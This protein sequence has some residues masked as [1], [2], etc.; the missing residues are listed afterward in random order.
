LRDQR[1]GTVIRL[2]DA[3]QAAIADALRP[4]EF[5]KAAT[6]AKVQAAAE[7]DLRRSIDQGQN[8]VPVMD[9]EGNVSLGFADKEL[10]DIDA[11]L[12]AADEIA[13]CANPAVEAAE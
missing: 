6:D 4:E 11:E 8:R 10:H 5:E 3:R 12:K 9:A 13:A 7:A 1:S 2:S